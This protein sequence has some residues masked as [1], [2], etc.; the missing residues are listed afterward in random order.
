MTVRIVSPAQRFP[1]GVAAGA[2]RPHRSTAGPGVGRW[3]IFERR[4][5]A[6]RCPGSS[7]RGDGQSRGV[8]CRRNGNRRS[9]RRSKASWSDRGRSVAGGCRVSSRG[10]FI[11]EIQPQAAN[12]VEQLERQL[13][14]LEGQAGHGPG[15]GRRL[16]SRISWIYEAARDFAVQAAQEMVAAAEAKQD[17]KQETGARLR[18]Q[19]AAGPAE[20]RTPDRACSR[21]ASSPRR[22]SRIAEEGPGCGAGRSGSGPA[23]GRRG[24]RT[25][26]RRKQHELEQK[27]ARHKPKWTTPGPCGRTPWARRPPPRRE[28]GRGDQTGRTGSAGDHGPARRHD[29]SPAGVRA[30]PDLKEGDPLFTI[31]PDATER[32]VE[33]WVSGNDTP[34]IQ[35]GD[36]VRLQF[37]GWPAVQFAG[38]PSVA[39]GTF[40][41]EVVGDRRHRQR[42]RQISRPE[43]NRTTTI[44][45]PSETLSA[46]RRPSQRLGHAQPGDAGLRDLAT[47]ERLPAGDCRGADQS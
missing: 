44:T 33:L 10:Q 21:K 37:E 42:Q 15:E 29:F 22:K 18:G 47:T 16:R 8:L 17:A 2:V 45:W 14:D 1:V 4:R 46:T 24:R 11:L 13:Q 26:G 9:S 31:V 32:A 6:G 41:G 34:L 27:G 19:R 36:H 25:N 5:D 3:P 23:G 20:L 30:R 35:S 43:S 28:T 40:G 38:W 12:L 39:V 7:P